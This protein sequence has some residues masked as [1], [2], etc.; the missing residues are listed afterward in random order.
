MAIKNLAK[1]E[2][3][4]RELKER[5]ELRTAGSAAGRVNSVRETRDSEGYPALVLSRDSDEAAGEPVIAIRIKQIDAVSKDVFG[6]S[7]K[8]YTPHVCDLAYELDGSAPQ[9]AA[10]DVA[11]AV[12]ELSRTGVKVEVKEIADGTAVTLSAM[13]AASAAL[14]LDDLRWPTKGV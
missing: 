2:A 7:M 4:V 3:L 11:L 13:D 9:P 8:A 6:N 5:L 1:A 10:K 12:W 14:E